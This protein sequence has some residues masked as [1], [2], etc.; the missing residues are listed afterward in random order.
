[1]VVAAAEP[2]VPV[3]FRPPLVTARLP[4]KALETPARVRVAAPVLTR[5]RAEVPVTKVPAYV[6]S[7]ARLRVRVEASVAWLLVTEAILA[8]SVVP[9]VRPVSVWV[10]PLRSKVE[11]ADDARMRLAAGLM[12]LEA[13]SL[14]NPSA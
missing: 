3:R 12:P 11:V 14:S 9:L 10:L 1:M 2:R 7:A 5:L 6:E 8:T 13:A 4:P